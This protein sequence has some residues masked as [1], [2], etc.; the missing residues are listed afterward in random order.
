MS[1]S[2]RNPD[3]EPQTSLPGYTSIIPCLPI[4]YTTPPANI[5]PEID[6]LQW[7]LLEPEG[8]RSNFSP[9]SRSNDLSGSI[10]VPDVAHC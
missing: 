3:H 2:V 7:A 6:D 4:K 1:I 9:K 8:R 5:P 10:A